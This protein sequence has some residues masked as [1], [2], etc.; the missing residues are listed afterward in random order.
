MTDSQPGQDLLNNLSPGEWAVSAGA[1]WIL[2]V[3]FLVGYTIQE[4]YGTW[5]TQFTAPLSLAILVA[6]V[7]KN[8]G[9]TSTWNGLYPG[10]VLLAGLGIVVFTAADLLN[11]LANDF[12][13]SAEFYELTAYVAAGAVAFGMWSIRNEAT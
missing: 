5:L 11:G 9:K 4:E 2:V 1:L 7:V 6:V 10:T 8:S 12:S 3:D 13:D